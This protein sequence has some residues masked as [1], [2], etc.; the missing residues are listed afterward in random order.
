MPKLGSART[1]WCV[2][3]L[4]IGG[5]LCWWAVLVEAWSR[6]EG[7]LGADVGVSASG[8]HVVV[9]STRLTMVPMRKK[10]VMSARKRRRGRVMLF[11]SF[12]I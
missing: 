7:E 6:D 2:R 11:R 9:L 3:A 10:G 12:A 1:A 5:G 4:L 8:F